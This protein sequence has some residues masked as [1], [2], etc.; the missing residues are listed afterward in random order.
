ML[1]LVTLLQLKS[2]GH[3]RSDAIAQGYIGDST[4]Q[5]ENTANA[6]NLVGKMNPL[7]MFNNFTDSISMSIPVHIPSTVKD[8]PAI[9]E[10]HS[11]SSQAL[12]NHYEMN[13]GYNN[14]FT[15]ATI[16][17]APV[18]ERINPKVK[19]DEDKPEKLFLRLPKRSFSDLNG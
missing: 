12:K 15:G 4:M 7:E 14:N 10:A 3:W 1:T 6:F 9:S 16:I 13:V 11:S 19:E 8:V 2:A 17:F 5:K 18:I